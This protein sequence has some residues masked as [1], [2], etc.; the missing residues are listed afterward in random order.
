MK[1]V[2]TIGIVNRGGDVPGPNAVIRGVVRSA[3]YDHGVRV[4]G[5]QWTIW[6]Y[7][8]PRGW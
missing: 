3:S 6:R 5:C 8:L 4:S 1:P 2:R 7:G